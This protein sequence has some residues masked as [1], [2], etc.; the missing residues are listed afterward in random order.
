MVKALKDNTV[1]LGLSDEN[2]NRL[3]NNQPIKF[4]L[5]DLGL[6][7]LNVIIFNA[8]DESTMIDIMYNH[9]GPTTKIV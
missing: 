8:K 5:K 6:Q 4:N 9:I 2:L 3:K 7:D 1:I